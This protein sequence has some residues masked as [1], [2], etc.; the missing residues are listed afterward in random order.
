MNVH[1][2][3]LALSRNDGFLAR[4]G[5]DGSVGLWTRQESSGEY[6]YTDLTGSEASQAAYKRLGLTER[7]IGAI[8][9]VAVSDDGTRVLAAPSRD[10][11]GLV[12]LFDARPAHATCLAYFAGH[13]DLVTALAFAPG[14]DP[15]V[16]LSGG[17][18]IDSTVRV[19]E[20]PELAQIDE[21]ATAEKGQLAV[22]APPQY[23]LSERAVWALAFV[24]EDGGKGCS[25]LRNLS[26][27]VQRVRLGASAGT[28]PD[29]ISLAM[30]LPYVPR[31]VL[32]SPTDADLGF[33]GKV[34]GSD[35]ENCMALRSLR[36]G[37]IVRRLVP[38]SLEEDGVESAV[39]N[40]ASST[41]ATSESWSAQSLTAG[42]FTPCGR[43]LLLAGYDRALLGAFSVWDVA[44]GARVAKVP[45][46]ELASGE[47]SESLAPHYSL[48]LAIC[49]PVSP[50]SASASSC[51]S[52]VCSYLVAAVAGD[53][54]TQWKL[55]VPA[56]SAEAALTVS[57]EPIWHQRV[58]A[59]AQNAT[60]RC[61]RFFVPRSSIAASAPSPLLLLGD[62]C[63]V[64]SVRSSVTGALLHCFSA[65]PSSERTGATDQGLMGLEI[66]HSSSAAGDAE[67][68]VQL[69]TLHAGDG[70]RIWEAAPLLRALSAQAATMAAPSEAELVADDAGV[71][72]PPVLTL[73]RPP[74]L[75]SILRCSTQLLHTCLAIEHCRRPATSVP[76]IAVGCIDGSVFVFTRGNSEAA[77][78]AA[79]AAGASVPSAAS[80]HG[81]FDFRPAQRTQL[82]QLVAQLEC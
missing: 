11:N 36:T 75:Q 48:D 37:Q 14:P 26:A 70:V 46:A 10:C 81:L 25:L 12:L 49:E 41:V 66:I 51:S 22:A 61:L 62:S 1:A 31:L 67:S 58:D 33:A 77:G 82:N 29:V 5:F 28:G 15:R 64:V 79:A 13:I 76:R 2:S 35:E 57:V 38:P 27:G 23:T 43:F 65:V 55:T 73:S 72:R 68:D 39:G 47:T 44:T 50:H 4:G 52:G 45:A 59:V 56:G 54:V 16:A 60:V 42:C 18:G 3:A 80:W 74:P 32:V 6:T 19:W 63:S 71:L 24:P 21:G 17:G 40:S 20:L 53:V 78:A 8:Q 9:A 30:E 69:V 34:V 7:A